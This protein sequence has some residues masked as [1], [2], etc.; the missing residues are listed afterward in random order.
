MPTQVGYDKKLQSGGDP[1]EDGE[2]ADKLP[3]DGFWQFVQKFIGS[4]NQS[5]QQLS[6]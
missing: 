3:W 2:Y 4:A 1:D 5:L 6:R